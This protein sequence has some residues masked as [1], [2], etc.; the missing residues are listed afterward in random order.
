[1]PGGPQS[2]SERYEEFKILFSLP[3]LELGPLCRLASSQ[4]LYRL[5]YQNKT[6]FLAWSASALCRQSD[7]RMSAKLMS[8]CEDRGRPVISVTDSYGRN[9]DFLDRSD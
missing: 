1:M 3:G 8:T 2:Q 7:R 5:R 9:L 6:N 4:S